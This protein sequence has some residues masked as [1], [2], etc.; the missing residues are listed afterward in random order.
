MRYES[1]LGNGVFAVYDGTDLTLKKSRPI[2]RPTKPVFLVPRPASL[3]PRGE[4]EIVLEPD[5]RAA[6]ENLLK[7]IKKEERPWEVQ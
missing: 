6:L 2:I 5:T 7:D 4:E 3:P 1:Y